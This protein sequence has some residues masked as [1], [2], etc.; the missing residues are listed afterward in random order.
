MTTKLVSVR[1]VTTII[2]HMT[3]D[4][5][6]SEQEMLKKLENSL[7]KDDPRQGDLFCWGWRDSEGQRG[8][9]ELMLY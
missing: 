4:N 3:R 1:R 9:L 6:A 5:A 2:T 7:E 8:Q